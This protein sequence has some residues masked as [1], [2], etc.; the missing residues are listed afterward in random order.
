M[1]IFYRFGKYILLLVRVFGRPDNFRVFIA[2]LFDEM[3]RIGIQSIG[4]VAMISLFMGMVMTLEVAYQLLSGFIAEEVVGMVVTDTSILELSPT[5]TSLVLAGRVG[6]NI[7]SEI[8]NMKIS[9][10]IDA[11]EVM[12]VNSAGYLI[13]PK[14]IAS[15]IMIPCLIIL[16]I[17]LSILGGVIVGELSDICSVTSFI[18]G[19][20]GSFRTFTLVF[21]LIKAFTFA[22]IISS[23]SSHLGYE[24]KGGALE[25]A[26]ASTRAVVQ[27]CVFILICDYLLAQL[28]L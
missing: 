18:D 19:A 2:K 25:V 16:S 14:I 26:R 9:E 6:S 20:R 8:G 23:I 5:V 10:Q 28:M 21:S 1:R 22:F 11:L 13:L 24:V 7:S 3:N 4:I 17:A 12:G 27:S 15:V